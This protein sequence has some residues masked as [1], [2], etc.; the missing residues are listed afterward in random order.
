MWIDAPRPEAAPLAAERQ[1]RMS[2]QTPTASAIDT[3]QR[4][5]RE[6]V[7]RY[8]AALNS[9]IPSEAPGEVNLIDAYTDIQEALLPE[10]AD[11]N[12]HEPSAMNAGYLLGIEI[13]RRM[14]GAPVTPHQPG[15]TPQTSRPAI[16]RFL[17]AAHSARQH[18]AIGGNLTEHGMESA[19]AQLREAIPVARAIALASNP[20]DDD[21]D[22][23]AG[24][25]LSALLAA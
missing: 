3:A 13:G 7:D 18:G 19:L 17:E 16:D 8:V 2:E 21:D 4:L 9:E 6:A 23:A 12:N 10:G 1:A 5:A 14:S 15:P 25:A 11:P 20:L 24:A 22:A